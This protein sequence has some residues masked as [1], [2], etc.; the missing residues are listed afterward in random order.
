MASSTFNAP[1][2]FLWTLPANI[3]VNTP[4]TV[5][6]KGAGGGAARGGSGV[7]GAGGSAAGLLSIAAMTAGVTQLQINVGGRGVRVAS[8]DF[9][10]GAGGYNGGGKGGNGGGANAL[11]ASGGGGATDI[12]TG[13]FA[14]ADRKAVAGGGGGST[15]WNTTNGGAGGAATGA[16]GQNGGITGQTVPTGGTQSAGGAA[17]TNP[18]G[19]NGSAGTSGNGGAGALGG[20]GTTGEGGGGGGG[21][22]FGGGGGGGVNVSSFNPSDAATG[23]GGSNYVGG[24]TGTSSTQGGGSASGADGLV[25]LSYNLVPDAPSLTGFTNGDDT[26]G[27][28]V[29]WLFSDPDAGDTQTAAD[30]RWRIG[31]GSWTTITGAATTGSTYTFPAGTFNTAGVIGQTVEWEVRTTDNHGAVGPWSASSFFTP[32]VESTTVPVVTVQTPNFSSATPNITITSSTAFRYYRL[33]VSPT[34]GGG[35]AEVFGDAGASVTTVTF[36]LPGWTYTNLTSYT[37][38]ARTSPYNNAY[39][40]GASGSVTSAAAIAAPNTPTITGMTADP[41]SGAVSFTITNTTV[42]T[43]KAIVNWVYRTDLT[44]G[45]PEQRISATA[46]INSVFT[47]WQAPLNM[48]LRYRIVAIAANGN[49]T[50]ST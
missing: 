26:I 32:R 36:N 16:S 50:S 40:W 45:T 23:A 2:T 43:N 17:G 6:L 44:S 15:Y 12:R 46:P 25:T 22:Y 21:G 19:L 41:F 34:P 11:G 49:G 33:A 48:Q 47:D 10:G 14:L 42:E 20:G 28:P 31:S 1:G 38:T 39:V 7:G 35:Y 29:A 18:A 27:V 37:F 13:A 5:T 4:I 3:D 30:V 8:G 9:I 24:L